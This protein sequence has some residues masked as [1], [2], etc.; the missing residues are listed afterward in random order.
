MLAVSPIAEELMV[1]EGIETTLSVIQET[2]RPGWAAGSAVMLRHLDLPK[3][4]Q[5]ITILADGDDP[6]ER[7]ARA[8]AYRWTAEG[9]SV[10]IARA[11]PGK[12]FNDVLIE[13]AS[14]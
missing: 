1:G 3:E 11:P 4:V 2:G 7:A 6:G 10:W 13:G 14:S 9:R 5:S 12:D 8:A